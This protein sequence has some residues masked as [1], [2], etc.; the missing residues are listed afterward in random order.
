[1]RIVIETDPTSPPQMAT[2]NAETTQ[3][4][5]PAADAGAGPSALGADAGT[6]P[7]A[8][9]DTGGPP[10]WLTTAI[11]KAMTESNSNSGEFS[12]ST[13]R[14]GAEDGGAGPPLA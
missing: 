5:A 13:D 7:S 10:E 3:P 4:I 12:A 11:A 8:A 1:M 2:G 14:A 6:G 9:F